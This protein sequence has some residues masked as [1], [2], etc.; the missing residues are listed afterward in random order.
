MRLHDIGRTKTIQ[1]LDPGKCVCRICG[2]DTGELSSARFVLGWC[3][4]SSQQSV[5]PR[6]HLGQNLNIYSVS[7]GQRQI[8]RAIFRTNL[9]ESFISHR[10]VKRLKLKVHRDPLIA[11]EATWGPT[12]IP[13]TNDYVNLACSR[14]KSHDCVPHRYYVVKLC[15]FDLLFGSNFAHLTYSLAPVQSHATEQPRS[16]DIQ[17]LPNAQ[18]TAMHSAQSRPNHPG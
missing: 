8:I 18:L 11:I 9:P 3:S 1:G 6:S 14:Q 17:H 7:N 15:S 2:R 4:D 16:R 5:S 10:I 12:R 13:P